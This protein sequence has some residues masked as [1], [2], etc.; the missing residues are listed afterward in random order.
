MMN[1][2]QVRAR[3]FKNQFICRASASRA[4]TVEADHI[5]L[6]ITC[7]TQHVH[8]PFSPSPKFLYV[9]PSGLLELYSL[10]PHIQVNF[11]RH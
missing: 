11:Y 6:L 5:L 8:R 4:W 10:R 9:L 2:F 3:L 7:D 1:K